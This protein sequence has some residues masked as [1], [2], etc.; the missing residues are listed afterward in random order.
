MLSG[1]V[2]AGQAELFGRRFRSVVG[3]LDGMTAPEARL[4]RVGLFRRAAQILDAPPPLVSGD[5]TVR[6]LGWKID[7]TQSLWRIEQDVPLA[8]TLLS[9]ITEIKVND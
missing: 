2:D 6:A 9:V 1:E 3:L 5:I 8:F 4:L 7:G